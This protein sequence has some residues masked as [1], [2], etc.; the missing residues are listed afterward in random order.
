MPTKDEEVE[1]VALLGRETDAGHHRR[2]RGKSKT[3]T[4]KRSLLLG[5]ALALFFGTDIIIFISVARLILNVTRTVKNQEMMEF[6]NP[7]IGLDELYSLQRTRPSTYRTVVNEPRL[8]AQV[9]IIEPDRVFPIDAH[10]WLSDFGLLSPPDRHLQVTSVIHTIAQFNVLDYGMEKCALTVRLPKRG[11]TL[12]H[13]FILP[14][15]EDTV[16]LSI[17]QLDAPRPLDERK[18]TW[19]SRPKC[20]KKLGTIV[21]QV[22]SEVEM[23]PFYCKSGSF[24]TYE[25]SCAEGSPDCKLET[26]TNHNETWGFFIKQ[27]Q[28]VV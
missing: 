17:C 15:Q 24:L 3:T 2:A 13:P 12:P 11:E 18:I 22:G 8:T 20:D 25:V 23:E 9:S 27:Y 19:A 28:S 4:N 16:E 14:A 5:I 10:R 7:Y 21:A 26:W 1:Y 6:R